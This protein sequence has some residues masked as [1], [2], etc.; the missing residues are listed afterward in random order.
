MADNIKRG[1]FVSRRAWGDIPWAYHAM[2]REIRR[3]LKRRRWA[4]WK[5][6]DA[7]GLQDGYS[8]KM[9]TPT[10]PTGRVAGYDLLD[11][12]FTA[13]VGRG[14]RILIVPADFKADLR[15]EADRTGVQALLDEQE[16]AE[17]ERVARLID[18]AAYTKRIPKIAQI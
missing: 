6:D 9:L 17:A 18:E 11:L 14:Y 5:L 10:S 7:A 12:A 13:L 16:D 2:C 1:R 4:L 15:R 3:H 8:S